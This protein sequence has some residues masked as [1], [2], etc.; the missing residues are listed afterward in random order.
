MGEI[1]RAERGLSP[2]RWTTSD[3]L[4][5]RSRARHPY[6]MRAEP[7]WP[8]GYLVCESRRS[9]R[10]HRKRARRRTKESGVGIPVVRNRGEKGSD[11]FALYW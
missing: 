6:R 5:C 8:F 7:R 9:R 11:R 4:P 3:L 2:L 1:G 10:F